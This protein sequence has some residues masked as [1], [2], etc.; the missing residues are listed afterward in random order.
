MSTY[1]VK[2]FHLLEGRVSGDVVYRHPTAR[3]TNDMVGILRNTYIASI[4][5]FKVENGGPIVRFIF[6][7]PTR[8]ARCQFSVVV[9]GIHG[10]VEADRGKLHA[11]LRVRR[12]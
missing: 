11:L 9:S 8:G 2:G 6:F 4:D 10:E 12:V 1:L 5:M 7:E 3:R